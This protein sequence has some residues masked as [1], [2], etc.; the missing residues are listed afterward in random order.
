MLG[1]MQQQST[2]SHRRLTK[3]GIVVDGHVFLDETYL[4]HDVKA[5]S[6][7]MRS[8]FTPV[9]NQG[10]IGACTVFTIAAI[11]EHFLKKQQGKDIDLS[12]SF[13]Y[14]NVRS[15]HGDQNT[16]TGSSYRDVIG[17][18]SLQG[19][20]LEDLH[21]YSQSLATRPDDEAYADA[22]SRLVAQA[23]NVEISERDIKSALADGYPV[24]IS[25]KIFD[26]FAAPHGF[27]SRPSQSE[28]DE[29]Q[30]GYHAMLIV[31]YD[32]NTHHF[33]VRNS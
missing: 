31:G 28:I 32:D 13:V 22:L 21:P 25:L 8:Q 17:S 29:G 15:Q 19:I 14:Y 1:Y 7:D 33:V 26:S 3:D 30:F 27:V 10:E 20:C 16:D 23:M 5:E 6:V 9:K 24:G 12:E 2:D 11:F 18:M 4:P